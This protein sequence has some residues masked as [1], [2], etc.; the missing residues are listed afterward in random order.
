MLDFQ[1]AKTLIMSKEK[2]LLLTHQKMD[3]DW[4]SSILS[5]W[6]FL[7]T[8]WKEIKIISTWEVP[9]S[10]DFLPFT[11]KIS[12]AKNAVKDFIISLKLNWASIDKLKY[13]TE[14]DKLN[15]AITPKNW[16][17]S[18]EWIQFSKG[19]WKFDLIICADTAD[20][21]NLW[22]LYFENTNL[23]FETPIL[24][25]DH[26]ATN[27]WFWQINLVDIT[28]ASSTM[29][30]FDL[31]KTFS[32]DWKEI[33]DED[34][35]TLLMAWLITDTGSFQHK[36]TSPKALEYAAD[37]M[38]L[39]ARQ[40]EIIRNIYKTKQLSML[41]IRWKILTNIQE[42]PI[43]R[44]VWSSVDKD[45][46][47]ETW[48]TI[49]EADWMIDE[50]MT[51][52]PWS[53]VIIL[54]KESKEN[55]IHIS[56][57]SNTI[58]VDVSQ[59]AQQYWWW[60]HKASAWFEISDYQNFQAEIWKFIEKIQIQQKER[61]WISQEDV[62]RI[63]EENKKIILEKI[64]KSKN[65]WEI[66]EEKNKQNDFNVNVKLDLPEI[67]RDETK[68]EEIKKP[69]FKKPDTKQDLETV[70]KNISENIIKKDIL[71]KNKTQEF[72]KETKS[73]QKKFESKKIFPKP[74]NP[75][76][77]FNKTVKI[78]KNTEKNIE[79]DKEESEKKIK[80][81]EKNKIEK[82]K[83]ENKKKQEEIEK[84]KQKEI[85]EKKI[86][87][88]ENRKILEEKKNSEKRLAEEKNKQ[89][90]IKNLEEDKNKK[91][92]E[93]KEEE[94]EPKTEWVISPQEA[95]KHA[96]NFYDLLQKTPQDNPSYKK[97][98]DSYMY[99]GKLAW[100]PWM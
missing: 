5:L 7:E 76:Q 94:E 41:K 9:D 62:K 60:W 100:W 43:S 18:Q 52:A 48:A 21:E 59:I 51:N 40:Q 81:E 32:E 72:K 64:E 79:K 49:E 85:L 28:S 91:K 47:I 99:Y 56:L 16:E 98:Y 36:N 83:I 53:E 70:N 44:V 75:K 22:D 30:I 13:N 50:L 90:N 33:I 68:R 39:W 24:N 96:R 31:I 42:D 20:L 69:E 63:E 11:K 77:K 73:E 84:N 23:F 38:D 4:L 17:I 3:I 45:D 93:T 92:T 8:L 19:I 34:I 2:I 26:H 58:A 87:Q 15:I 29:I 27:S 1:T 61:L 35:A 25:I 12:V 6:T 65:S 78:E 37:L 54:A 89:E 66:L 74:E 55:K 95:D 67:K 97:Y 86:K 80:E 88:E 71:E 10:F 46:F 57:R 14:W 82:N